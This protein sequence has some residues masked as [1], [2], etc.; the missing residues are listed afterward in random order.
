M[1]IRREMA[2]LFWIGAGLA[3][4]GL[5]VRAYSESIELGLWTSVGVFGVLLVT[6]ALIRRRRLLKWQRDVGINGSARLMAEQRVWRAWIKAVAM[7]LCLVVTLTAVFMAPSAERRVIQIVAL[8][9]VEVAICMLLLVDEWF[10]ERA[11]RYEDRRP[12]G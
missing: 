4:I 6:R 1:S 3:G 11:E 7:T 10:R 2:W 12:H 5:A 9:G 8:I